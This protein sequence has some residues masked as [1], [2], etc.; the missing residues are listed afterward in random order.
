MELTHGTLQA[1]GLQF[2]TLEI[3]TGPLA[4]CLHGFPDTAWTW[5]H[6]LP[7]LAAAGFRAVAP[8]LRGYAPTDVPADGAYQ[9]GALAADAIALHEALGGGDDAVLVGHDWGAMAAYGAAAHAP[10]RWRRIVTMAVPPPAAMARGFLDYD[11][12]RRSFYVFVFQ[13]PLAEAAVGQKDLAFIDGLWRDWS[14]GYDAADDVARV[15]DAL[16]SPA[17]LSAAIGYYRA[18]LDRTN[19]VPAYAAE[20]AAVLSPPPQPTLYLHGRADGALGVELVGDAG[21]WLSAE[22]R[23]DILDD[24]GH[25]LHLERPADVNERVVSWLTA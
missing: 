18:M 15:K 21:A 6:L 20:Q 23:V 7:E 12:L 22:S 13:T 8:Y 3:G 17:N 24:V 1:N 10:G 19:H 9:T 4:L 16:R 5:R 2:A 14:P 25:F 11:Q